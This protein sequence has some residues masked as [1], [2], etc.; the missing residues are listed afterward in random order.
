MAE[1]RGLDP[2]LRLAQWGFTVRTKVVVKNANLGYCYATPR[3]LRIQMRIDD[4]GQDGIGFRDFEWVRNHVA[5]RISQPCR[6]FVT[7]EH[8]YPFFRA[9]RPNVL[10]FTRGSS[11][12]IVPTARVHSAMADPI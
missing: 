11:V 7:L 10:L 1:N 4:L 5:L 2:D 9:R 6:R 8:E 3:Y 12:N